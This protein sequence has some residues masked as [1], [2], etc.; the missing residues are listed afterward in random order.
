MIPTKIQCFLWRAFKNALAT[1]EN[2]EKK[3]ITDNPICKVCFKEKETVEY[4]IFF[5]H[6]AEIT[7]FASSLGFTPNRI[8][9]QSIQTWWKALV[10]MARMDRDRMIQEA[11]FLCW[12]I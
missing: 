6:H 11:A 8:G 10:D 7:W 2:L 3:G 5:C 12:Q 1:Q 9:F 4:A